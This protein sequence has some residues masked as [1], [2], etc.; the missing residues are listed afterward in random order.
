M[1]QGLVRRIGVHTPH[2]LVADLRCWTQ[3]ETTA[4]RH[5]I[6]NA[7]VFNAACDLREAIQTYLDTLDAAFDAANG[8]PH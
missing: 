5:L 1:P 4:L 6:D 3:R 2:T 8:F 7:D